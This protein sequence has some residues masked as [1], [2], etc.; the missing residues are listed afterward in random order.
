MSHFLRKNILLIL[1]DSFLCY[2]NRFFCPRIRGYEVDG[3]SFW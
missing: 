3:D 2:G 1:I